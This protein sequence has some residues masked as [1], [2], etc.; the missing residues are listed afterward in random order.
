MSTG[1]HGMRLGITIA[2]LLT[3]AIGGISFGIARYEVEKSKPNKE[4]TYTLAN[5]HYD[6]GDFGKA[7]NFYERYYNEFEMRE[8][9][10]RIDYG[11][12]M[13][14]SGRQNEGLA[15]TRSVFD[16]DPHNG[17]AQYNLA[18]M[19]FTIGKEEQGIEW[20]KKCAVN[21]RDTEIASRARATLEE[22]VQQ[23]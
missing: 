20:L 7:A 17:A 15:M 14:K 12:S 18:I 22:L 23:K 16:I 2:I 9:T 6:A 21:T 10:V 13:F 19:Y 3:T 1:E 5:K 8:P 11:Y 4:E